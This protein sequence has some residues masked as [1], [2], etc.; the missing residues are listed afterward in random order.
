PALDGNQTIAQ[1]FAERFD[2]VPEIG[3]Q[4]PVGKAVLAV[5]KLDGDQVLEAS[6]RF[7]EEK[8]IQPVSRI[9]S[10][11]SGFLRTKS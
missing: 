1:L 11:L 8:N 7:N 5:R 2:E 4:L 10:A 3:D 9:R 6:L